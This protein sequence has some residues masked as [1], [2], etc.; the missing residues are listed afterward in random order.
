MVLVFCFKKCYFKS[1]VLITSRPLPSLSSGR[2]QD[3]YW[4]VWCC[5]EH[6]S[7]GRA[8]VGTGQVMRAWGWPATSAASMQAFQLCGSCPCFQS[9]LRKCTFRTS[10][11]SR[12]VGFTLSTSLL[13]VI[14]L[15]SKRHLYSYLF[16]NLGG[17]FEGCLL[18]ESCYWH[19]KLNI[20]SQVG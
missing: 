9:T 5:A 1:N 10:G 2:H 6:E 15:C 13:T 16:W 3:E 8:A 18:D 19:R 20:L 4:G 14:G 7:C 17:S 12:Q 11:T